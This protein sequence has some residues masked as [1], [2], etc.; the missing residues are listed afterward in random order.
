MQGGG[1]TQPSSQVP[2]V[3]RGWEAPLALSVPPTL[4]EQRLTLGQ[5]VG[6]GGWSTK[7]VHVTY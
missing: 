1:V 5:G 6:V 2:G 3:D 4:P 7:A